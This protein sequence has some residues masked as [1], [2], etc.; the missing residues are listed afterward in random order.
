MKQSILKDKSKAFAL[1]VIRLYKYLCEERKEYILS[2][3]LLRSGTSIGANIAEAF[4]G[5]SEADFVSKLSIAQKETG[6]TIY[7]L[8]LLHESDYL[9]QNEY[10]SV[11]SDAEELIKLLTSSIKTMKEKITAY[12][13][14]H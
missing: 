6:E 3:Q 2:K 12:K 9:I 7:W 8:E 13:P 1:R 4:Y 14:N 11:Y 5:Q 10:D